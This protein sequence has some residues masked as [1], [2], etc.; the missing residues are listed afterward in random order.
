MSTMTRT[1]AK[2]VVSLRNRTDQHARQ[3]VGVYGQERVYCQT[4][5]IM[6]LKM[7]STVLVTLRVFALVCN[8]YLSLSQ[9]FNRKKT[10]GASLG[11]VHSGCRDSLSRI[12]YTCGMR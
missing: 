8:S 7:G 2:G 11:R 6:M 5:P 9:I 12:G 1:G 10:K 4:N 3:N